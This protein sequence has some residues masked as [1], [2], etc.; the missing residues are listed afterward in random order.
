MHDLS[1]YHTDKDT[2]EIYKEI[3]RNLLIVDSHTHLGADI[4]KHS[5]APKQLIAMMEKAGIDKAISFPLNNP[6]Y[7]KTFSIPNDSILRASKRYPNRIIPFFRLNPNNDKWKA[8]LKKRAEQGFRG[9]KLHPRSQRFRINSKNAKEI[10]SEAEK[11]NLMLIIHT[12][13]GVD[14]LAED[15]A[16]VSRTFSKVRLILAHSAFPDM[17]KVIR[18][19]SQRKNILFETSSLRTFD[20]F[21]LLKKVSY[22]R[23]IFGSDTPYYDQILSLEVLI[24][25]AIILKKTQN[26]I[27]EMMGGN[28]IRWLK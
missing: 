16:E 28:I 20:I 1:R 27:K 2:K 10:F 11:K 14:R 25:T 12:G 4:D 7:S 19:V 22:K 23:V 3:F 15:V 24:N 26:Q 13:F 9:I 17:H 5:L 6:R 21:D 8:E 18:K